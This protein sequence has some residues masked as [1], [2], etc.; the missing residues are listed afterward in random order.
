MS[1]EL[2]RLTETLL[3]EVAIV[4]QPYRKNK[5]VYD[6]AFKKGLAIWEKKAAKKGLTPADYSEVY[7]YFK[8]KPVQLKQEYFRLKD[9]GVTKVGK[10]TLL[11]GKEL[12]GA[13]GSK[14]FYKDGSVN[15]CQV[16]VKKSNGKYAL[17]NFPYRRFLNWNSTKSK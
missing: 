6:A 12:E 5:E 14:F 1:K 7:K 4:G 11:V 15:T 2:K 8:K 13:H 16:L 3:S 10:W 17:R 9:L